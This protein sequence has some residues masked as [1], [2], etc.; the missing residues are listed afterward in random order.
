[1]RSLF[2]ISHNPVVNSGFVPTKYR[3]KI[4][5][6]PFNYGFAKHAKKQPYYIFVVKLIRAAVLPMPQTRQSQV[7]SK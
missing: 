7:K 6:G 4:Y 2:A 3:Y 5:S 1:M